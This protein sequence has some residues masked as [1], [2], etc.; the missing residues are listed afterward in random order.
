MS[1]EGGM[2]DGL[3]S[4]QV[5]VR[6]GNGEAV[7]WTGQP[8]LALTGVDEYLW[9]HLDRGDPAARSALAAAGLEPRVQDAL[10]AVETRP[11][12]LATGKGLLVVLRGVNLN[13]GAEPEDMVAVRVWLEPGRVVSVLGRNLMAVL[14]LRNR[15]EEEGRGPVDPGAWLAALV[16]SIVERLGPV[17]DE[18]EE[19]G[20]RLEE[21]VL[22]HPK[23]GL[24]QRVGTHRRSCI[25]VRR[26]LA[27]MRET[28]AGLALEHGT[29]LDEGARAHLHEAAERLIRIV[30][31]LD[32]LRDRAAVTHD[33]L[34]AHLSDTINSTMFR[35]SLVAAV[36][37][38][39]SLLTSLLGINVAGIP[40]ASSPRAFWAVCLLLLVLGLAEAL[41]FYK[42]Y[43]K[44]ER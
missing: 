34:A 14:D 9:T 44:G 11:R 40:G 24:R 32:T 2:E 33:E 30:E 37:L 5:R 26:H 16:R 3:R 10:L 1:R 8:L 43:W 35:L 25:Q 28:V 22:R 39:L 6:E 13:P 15:V 20:D 7:A 17:M 41:F 18:V 4:F 23:T 31:D 19:D 21:E 29:L 12:W 27:P 36:F 42:R 38:P